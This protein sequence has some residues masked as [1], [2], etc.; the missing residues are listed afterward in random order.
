M[1]GMNFSSNKNSVAHYPANE[2]IGS[3]KDYLLNYFIFIFFLRE[4]E[5][6]PQLF[7]DDH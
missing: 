1:R 4:R 5:I 6:S 3:D 7:Y 2:T